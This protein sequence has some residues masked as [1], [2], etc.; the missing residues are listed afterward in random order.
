MIEY[1]IA[2]PEDVKFIIETIENAG[3]EAYAVG[4]CVRDSLLGRSPDDWDITTSAK[5]T[6]VKELFRRTVDTGIQHGTVTVMLKEKGYEVTTY[7]IDGEY[8]DSRHPK[9]VEFTPNLK[10]DLARRDFTI[11]AMA[12]NERDGIVDE[13]GGMD[14]LAK[15]IIRAVGFAESRFGEDA[16]RIFRAFRFA[17]VLNFDIAE[18]TLLAARKLAPTLERISAERINIELTKLLMSDNPDHII[19]LYENGITAVMLPEFD[20]C[21]KT[22]QNNPHH[23]Y[24]VGEHI[25]HSMKAL[26]AEETEDKDELRILRFALLLHD[27]GKPETKTTDK[28]GI[29]H[30]YGHEIIGEKIA[31]DVLKRLKSDNNTID[32]VRR[33]VRWH[34]TRPET[35]EKSVRK[36][37]NN[38]GEDIYPMLLKFHR[39]DIAAQSDYKREEKIDIENRIEQIYH[40][41]IERGDCISLKMLSVNGGDLIAAG[42]KPGKELGEVLKGLLELVLE[43]PSCNEK[44]ILLRKV[45]EIRG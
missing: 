25:A 26:K 15:G 28:L 41:I 21:M 40:D 31:V 43:D 16:L 13:F 33:L 17:A 19:R 8:E 10:E 27:M 4:G 9:Q 37:V 2:L 34:D 29:D 38:V 12:Y 23:C 1:N 39:A 45:K 36:S 6:E 11:N 3:F 14:D 42:M 18:D 30:F 35:T 5:P 44:E 20:R 32:R 7:R 22:V 24:N